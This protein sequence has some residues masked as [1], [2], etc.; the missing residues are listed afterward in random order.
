MTVFMLILGAIA[1]TGVVATVVEVCRD[2]YRRVPERE[3]S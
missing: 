3:R 2:G 1:L